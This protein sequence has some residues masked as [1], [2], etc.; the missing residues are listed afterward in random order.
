MNIYKTIQYS[1]FSLVCLL[2]SPFVIAG[3]SNTIDSENYVQLQTANK[4]TFSAYVA[5]PNNSRKAILLIHGWWGLT[6]DVKTWANEFAVKGYRV[7]A[8]DLYNNQIAKHPKKAKKLMKSVKQSIAN[9]KYSAAINAL[10]VPGRKIAI[11]GRSYGG[12]QT[13]HAASV[14]KDKVS[15]AIIYYPYG[16]LITE[17]EKLLSI[18]AP[19]LGHFASDDFFLTPDK[20]DD[21]T[22]K[23]LDSSL[24]MTFRTY[25]A[26]HGFDK[27][28]G[29]NYHEAAGE[30]AMR[31][32]YQFLSKHLN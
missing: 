26:K 3:Q 6:R 14:G 19:V 12:A 22:S 20:L 25:K 17:K 2:L 24:N 32:T 15:A 21:F 28:H 16:K 31:R 11:L 7:M 5:G 23:I 1:L 18:K 29:N 27:Q 8:I 4:E 13:L 9:E 10:S 30:L